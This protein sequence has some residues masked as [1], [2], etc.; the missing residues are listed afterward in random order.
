M[1]RPE[2]YQVEDGKR[3]LVAGKFILRKDLLIGFQ[4]GNYDHRQQ[5]IIDPALAYSTYLG[6]NGTDDGFGIAVDATGNAYVVG[7]TTSTNF[8]MLNGYT[9][10]ANANGIAFV[11]KLNPTGTALL[12]STYLGGTGGE[13]GNGIAL[14][15]SGNVYVT[16]YTMSSDF[17]VLNGFQTSIGTTDAN[18]FVA[19]IDTTQTGTASLVYSTYLGGG[20]NSTNPIGDI[21]YAIAV[22][23]TGLAY[24][25]GQTTSDTSVAAFPITA[26]ACQSALVSQSGNAFLTVLDTNQSGGPSL[27]YSTYLGGSSTGF[28]DYGLG[29]SV[30]ALG[31]AFV[32]GST[33]SSSP[34]PFPTTS[35]AYQS[36]LN[37]EYGNA[38]VTEIATTQ[39][40]SAS[41]VYSTY[42]GGSG[43][44]SD[45]SGDTALSITL[46][47][48]GKV[49]LSGAASSPDFPVSSG[50]Y[51]TTNPNDG[52]SFVAKLDLTQSGSQSLLYS[53]YLGGTGG[54]EGFGIAVDA[55]GNAYV[56]GITAS[57]DFPTTAGA[58]ESALKSSFSDSF[59][60]VLNSTAT[61]LQYSTYLG[62]SCADGDAGNAIALDSNGNPYVVGSTCSSDFPTYP[63]SAY[64]TSLGGAQN[65]F[66][67]KFALVVN[68]SVTA[69]V[70]PSPDSSGW[71]NSSV[72]VTFTCLP[73]GAPISSC[74]SPAT[75]SIEGADQVITGTATDTASNT[76]TTSV[77]V[78]LDFTPPSLSISSPS[79]AATVSTPYV[80]ISGTLTDSLSGP[81]S[82]NCSGVP[83]V[84][85]DTNFSCTVQ[86]SSVSNSITVIGY[87]LAGNSSTTTLNVTV[88]MPAPTSL[89]A[90]PANPNMIVG[91][92]QA[93]T[94]I[95]QTGTS[96]PDAMWSVS[97]TSVA[98]F[99]SGSPNTLLGNAAGTVTLT[100]T[101]ATVSGQTTVTVLPN[102]SLSVGTVLWSAPPPSGYTTQKI[103][104]AVPTANGPDLYAIDSDGNY[105][106]V[107]QA[108]KA[109]GEQLWTA[110]ITGGMSYIA[111][112][113][114]DNNG[115]LILTGDSSGG[116]PELLDIAGPTG[117]QNWQF[118]PQG[119]GIYSYP[120]GAQDIAVGLDGTLYFAGWASDVTG[121]NWASYLYAINGATG[122]LISQTQLPVSNATYHYNCNGGTTDTYTFPTPSGPPMVA[123]DGSVYIEFDVTQQT[124]TDILYS[125][126]LC[127]PTLAPYTETLELLRVLPRGGTQTQVLASYSTSDWGGYNYA[128][129]VLDGAPYHEPGDVIPD[130][131]GGVLASYDAIPN[132]GSPGGPIITDTTSG[133]T[134]ILSSL[135]DVTLDSSLVLDDN[136]TAFATDGINVVS[137]SI[138]NLQQ[139]WTYASQGET[140]SF[141]A[142]TSGGGITVNDS[143]LG[144]IQLDPHGNASTPVSSLEAAAPLGLGQTI[145]E[146]P[147]LAPWAKISNGQPSVPAGPSL[148]TPMSPFPESG[149]DPQGQRASVSTASL[150]VNFSGKLSPGDGLVFD[151]GPD[152]VACSQNLGLYAC[153]PKG[154][155]WNVEIAATVSDDASNWTVHQRAT[156][157]RQGNWIDSQGMLHPAQDSFDTAG[158]PGDDD[159]CAPN[160]TRPGCE[161]VVA[162]QQQ[163]GQKNIFWIDTPGSPYKA[164][165]DGVWDSL[166]SSEHFTSKVCNR[167]N[168]CVRQAWFFDLV[169]DPGSNLDR[170]LSAA[171]PAGIGP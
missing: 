136:N 74:S 171:G 39:S 139:N 4:I 149:G 31:D 96:R 81:G 163:A 164:N 88:S 94:A 150:V 151:T 35:S 42:L 161:G 1:R 166:N 131:D 86:L 54:D 134:L 44:G 103:V 32:A 9:S 25:T 84:L 62:G 59:F 101:V 124:W 46:D 24:V 20:G 19:R 119:T 66:V 123:P 45:E 79:N 159:P 27:V 108:L 51:Q 118:A 43:D 113:L 87:D 10:S 7:Q 93:F 141:V 114:G 111:S 65:A 104:Q 56:V 76:A 33:T 157:N 121:D 34:T 140:L 109:D 12:Y 133:A 170:G 98:S 18:A 3:R 95:D 48:L 127:V 2:I 52:R 64:Q 38:F 13:S 49:Y 152:S 144:V 137:F 115:G 122:A 146:A 5:L 160:D 162:L 99:L 97:D 102:S 15:P 6:G 83:A 143:Q 107:V 55:N 92:T 69:S 132:S 61:G 155:V 37:S 130:G 85:T 125:L 135:Q 23:A 16:G 67:T 29:V 36:S 68:P 41:L 128:T 145:T 30:D 91:G 156:G 116:T 158:F 167:S 63:P 50:A 58:Y 53:T 165:A 120:V 8:P 153:L 28:G 57:S 75:V 90:S 80:T 73:G 105:D 100:A 142:A 82:V 26:S 72:T 17:P 168:I 110:P 21:G 71:N 40:G 106:V 89:T 138:P 78:N 70:S 154:W 117:S 11:S 147:L 60:T 22:D 129:G 77:T 47:S 169:V 112:G 126:G 14:D 148:S